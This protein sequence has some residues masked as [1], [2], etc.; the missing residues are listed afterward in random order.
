MKKLLIILAVIPM[1]VSCGD[2]FTF[3]PEADE[4]DG[5]TMKI[6]CGSSYLMKG[7]S[8]A[9]TA[10]FEPLKPN[11]SSIYWFTPDAEYAKIQNDTL[12]A[13]SEG[14]IQLTASAGAGKVADT[15]SVTVLER[16]E[17]PGFEK[18]YYADMVFY[19]DIDVAGNDYDEDNMIV[20]AFVNDKLRGIAVNR[21]AHGKNYTEIRVWADA[22]TNQGYVTFKCYDRKNHRYYECD[23]NVA[24]DAY[25]TYGTLSKLYNITF[26]SSDK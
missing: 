18:L 6:D 26:T 4:W 22:E 3:A 19:S 24:F 1:F 7:D 11:G 17:D 16:W 13:L 2:F 10:T 8:I 14:E 15:C 21:T 5:V 12:I 25:K 9:L 23:D 20:G